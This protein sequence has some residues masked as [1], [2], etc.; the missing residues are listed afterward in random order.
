MECLIDY[1]GVRYT[2]TSS[3]P[4]PLT[5]ES[6]LFINDLPG[7]TVAQLSDINNSDQTTFLD[8]WAAIQRRSAR[9]FETT[10]TNAMSKK[11]RLKKITEAFKLSES[12]DATKTYPPAAG[13]LRGIYMDCFVDKSAFHHIPISTVR[14]YL[15]PSVTVPA[16]I[17]LCIYE[18]HDDKL[19][20]LDTFPINAT[21]TGWNSVTINKKYHDSRTLFIAYDASTITSASIPLDSYDL[22]PYL[23]GDLAQ[24]FSHI[25]IHGAHYS[26]GH[27][28]DTDETETYGL[29][30]TLGLQCSFDTLVCNYKQNLAVAWWYL[31]GSELMK[32]RIYTD[33]VNRYTTVD[34][35]KARELNARFYADYMN[36]L[37]TFVDSIDLQRDWCI[38]CD[39]M[40]KLVEVLP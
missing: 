8:L 32:E 35:D 38:D 23:Y 24:F 3:L 37:L 39:A 40:V 4:A 1:I 21:A 14:L 28:T 2:Q 17:D 11:F 25:F 22:N 7:I 36:E 6:G 29:T 16:T 10:F 20:L 18:V 26:E 19:T 13:E 27:F 5:P 33:R 34:L 9:I 12:V 31:L 30:A 15:D